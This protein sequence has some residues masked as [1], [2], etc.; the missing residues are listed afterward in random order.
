[1]TL[2]VYRRSEGTECD[3][4]EVS[5]SDRQAFE[6]FILTCTN[7]ELVRAVQMFGIRQ[8][9]ALDMPDM[10]T[11][12]MEK[13]CDGYYEDMASG[14]LFKEGLDALEEDFL[15][16]GRDEWDP[17]KGQINIGREE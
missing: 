15:E 2:Y 4:D 13:I 16:W 7:D 6:D 3:V 1:M 12:L 10:L 9:L 17:F 14:D 5:T 11:E 8:Q